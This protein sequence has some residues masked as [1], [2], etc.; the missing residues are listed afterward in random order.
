MSI[1]DAVKR[2]ERAGAEESQMTRKLKE[3]AAETARLIINIVAITEKIPVIDLDL[4]VNDPE[5]CDLLVLP[6]DYMAVRFSWEEDKGGNSE[7]IKCDTLFLTKPSSYD[8]DSDTFWKSD[9]LHPSICRA[10]AL[11][12]AEDLADGLMDEIAEWMEKENAATFKAVAA[13]SKN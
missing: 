3:A 5:S 12:F 7:I 9:L 6:R 8:L 11:D 10:V 13:L 4:F 1:I 2:L